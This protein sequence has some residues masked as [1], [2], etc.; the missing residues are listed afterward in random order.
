MQA[1]FRPEWLLISPHGV[2]INFPSGT[3]PSQEHSY[4]LGLDYTQ[5]LQALLR[6]GT[7]P[8]PQE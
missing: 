4:M 7:Q 2:E 1:A 5:Q 8:L 6:P 3:L